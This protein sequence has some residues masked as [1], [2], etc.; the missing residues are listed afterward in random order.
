M[1]ARRNFLAA[2]AGAA[3]AADAHSAPSVRQRFLDGATEFEFQRYTEPSFSCQLPR[4]NAIAFSRR[5][6]MLLYSS[7]RAG[8]V[9][10]WSMDLKSSEHKQLSEGKPVDEASL[11]LTVDE[12]NVLYTSD[13]KLW[14]SPAS[15]LRPR[16]LWASGAGFCEGSGV[17]AIAD[18]PSAIVIEQKEGGSLVRR[19]PLAKGTGAVL[20]E[21]PVVVMDPMPRP[22]RASLALRDGEGGL[23]LALFDGS[24]PR[25]L[26][27][28][29]GKLLAAAWSTDGRTLTYLLDPQTAGKANQLRELNPDTG[30]DTFL[31]P[32]SQFACFSGNSDGSV[33]VGASRSKAQPFVLLLVRSV[34]RELTICEHKSS[35]A[36]T[37]RP[38]FTPDSQRIYFQSD[39]EGKPVLYGM[40]VD[41]LVEKTENDEEK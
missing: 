23:W 9:H 37:V 14:M 24:K 7:D 33:I 6:R 36:S 4:T 22:K 19:V 16:A 3:Y 5:D 17:A 32:T 13:G 25:K 20:A 12:R 30:E 15:G 40:A 18:G 31:A 28:E 39:R 8:A 35:D 11:T 26:K 21:F 10:A 2:M 29:S 38:R 34:K 41:K 1:V 27:T